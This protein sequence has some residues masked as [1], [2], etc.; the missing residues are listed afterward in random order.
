MMSEKYRYLLELIESKRA[1]LGIVGL[2]QVGLPT[3]LSFADAGF[4]VTGNDVNKNLLDG[5]AKGAIPF[6][7]EGLVDLLHKCLQNNKFHT[8]EKT[9]ELIREC[10]VIIV[11]V[12]TPLTEHVRPDMSYLENIMQIL[13]NSF[14]EGKLVIIESSIPPGTFEDMILPHLQKK[15]MLGNNVWAAFVPERLAPGS[16]TREIRTTPRV[17]GFHDIASGHLAQSLYKKMISGQVITTDVRIAEISKLVE[18][19]YRDVNV[20]LANEVSLICEIYGIDFKE[21][22]TVCNSH[23]RVNLHSA[24]PGVGGPCL[25]KD[26]YL[27]LNPHGGNTIESKIIQHARNVNDSMPRRVVDLIAS[28]LSFHGKSLS[29]SKIGIWGVA[30]KANVSDTR[31][32]PAKMVISELIRQGSHVIVFDPYAQESFGGTKVSDMWGAVEGSDALVIITD[33]NTFRNAD[34]DSIKSKLSTPVVVDTRRMFDGNLARSISLTY[35]AIGY[36]GL[37]K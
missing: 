16:A 37:R 2:G 1:K 31:F 36:P 9:E 28:G 10:D 5:L 13:A 25:P 17:I 4:S 20:A 21:L 27:L 23:P 33:H 24:G 3:A 12:P 14:L 30:Y 18:N 7:E 8:V 15:N 26:P 6:E 19:T 32:S 29:D 22:Q 11:C 35:L 34:L